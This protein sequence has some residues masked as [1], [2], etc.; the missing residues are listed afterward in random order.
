MAIM[1]MVVYEV[2]MMK[3]YRGVN[4]LN[5]FEIIKRSSSVKVGEATLKQNH[6]FSIC[7]DHSDM[8][9]MM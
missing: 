3:A 9:N 1:V 7:T 8:L 6:D 2:I 4:K 5:W